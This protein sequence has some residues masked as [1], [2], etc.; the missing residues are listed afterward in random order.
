MRPNDE[1]KRPDPDLLLAKVQTEEKRASQ[2]KLRIYF[3][4]S[5]G[6][7][8]TYSM[9]V[10]ANKINREGKQIVVGIVETH[11][12]SETEKLVEGLPVLPRRSIAYHGKTIEE[13]DLDSALQQTGKLILIDE[14]AHSNAPG[15]RHPKRWQD[16]EE[17][18]EA[19]IDVFTTLNVQH[20]ESLNDV[21]NGI[22]GIQVLETVPD[23]IFDLA[24]EVILVD[25]PAEELLNRL[26]T[27][28]VYQAPQVENAAHNFFRK[29][30]L[31]ALRELAL[32]RTAE[33]VE[34]DVQAYRIEQ[35]ITTVWKTNSL[36]LV[37]VGPQ[38][39]SEQVVRSAARLAGQLNA[40]W[41]AIYVE[42]PKLQRAKEI[43]RERVLKNL[44]LAQQL[45]AMTAVLS[46]SDIAETIA[47]YA[48]EHNFSKIILG[49]SKHNWF[50]HKSY[51]QRIATLIPDVDLLQIG[52]L[53]A[54][55]LTVEEAKKSS[56]EMNRERLNKKRVG[57]YLYA[58]SAGLVSTLVTLPLLPFLSADNVAMLFL[59]I[60]LIVAIAFG[61]GP[62]IVTT[63]VN[64]TAYYIL[65]LPPQ[66]SLKIN[67]Y[68][69]FIMLI[70]MLVIGLV[71]SHLIGNMRY[72]ARIASYREAR[73]QA[74]YNIARDLSSAFESETIFEITRSFIKRAFNAQAT[75]LLPN[76]MGRLQL[77]TTGSKNILTVATMPGL[78]LGIAQWAFDHG[79]P[80]GLSTDTLPAS[81]IFY[82][83]LLAPIQAR[84]L[85]AIEPKDKNWLLIPEQRQ[86]LDTFAALIAITLERVHYIQV[87]QDALI[88]MESEQLRNSLLSSLSH[89]L[90]TP[91]ISLLKLSKSLLHSSSDLSEKQQELAKSLRQETLK[92]SAS[93]SN[94][95]DMARI[96]S[97]DMKLNL[98]WQIFTDIVANA[99]EKTKVKLAKHQIKTVYINDLPLMHLD[100]VMIER[101]L[102][103]LLENASKY[104]P[105]GTQIVLAVEA[106]GGFMNVNVYDDGPGL[107]QGQ[108][109]TIFEKFTRGSREDKKPGIGLGLAICRAIIDA[110]NG[111]IHAGHSPAG[112]ASIVFSIPIQTPPSELHEG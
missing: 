97:G 108:E 47:N 10:E 14:L 71:T 87:A 75:L 67:N 109:E 8:K 105:P 17:L 37:C 63:Y 29:G 78:D 76:D 2:G 20:L 19:G 44:K 43:Q 99:L 82:L 24:E 91:L 45:G 4:A 53:H 74:L 69:S 25:V 38:L 96:E 73:A 35:A 103:D 56:I 22:T 94:L 80:A 32:R 28:K 49:R 81:T 51:L 7:G 101:V 13:F 31:I 68:Q 112:G 83:P 16:I 50:W 52:Y 23:R 21:V 60:V 110:H 65:F 88:Y 58:I 79:E 34:E 59:L 104:T 90:R 12:R 6:V 100:A 77:S 11:G 9:L 70:M 64:I 98:Q 102:C 62:A 57:H 36:L 30:N 42:T 5:A 66:F 95:L 40:E 27:G 41:H 86:Q 93:I 107:P 55:A 72:K 89:D 54:K 106:A 46:G 48:M 85:L 111:S 39:G 1:L 15:S 33:R 92:M 3:G 26:R 18:L 84:G 61:R